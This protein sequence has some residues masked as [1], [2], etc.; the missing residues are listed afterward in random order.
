MLSL[1]RAGA[2][3][4]SLCQAGTYWTGSGESFQ[5]IHLCRPDLKDN[6]TVRSNVVQARV[7]C[8]GHSEIAGHAEVVFGHGIW[9]D[10]S[11]LMPS[12]APG[13]IWSIDGRDLGPLSG[14]GGAEGVR[15]S[16]PPKKP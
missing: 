6:P 9:P 14:Y 16:A 4:C 13:R 2:S 11:C 10:L 8:S 1:C 12:A 15:G 7:W 5:D 3:S